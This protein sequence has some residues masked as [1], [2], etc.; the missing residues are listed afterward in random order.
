MKPGTLL[1]GIL[2]AISLYLSGCTSWQASLE[3]TCD[4]YSRDKHFTWDVGM[5]PGDSA[6]VTLCSNP[7]TGFQWSESAQISDETVLK[8]TGHR[9]IPPGEDAPG[10]AGKE[11]WTFKALK[12]G[13]A[14]VFMGYSRPWEGGEKE[15]WSFTATVFVE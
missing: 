5:R 15:E 11:E 13:T 4:H 6:V 3:I 2:A 12:E 8:Q 1:V 7:T 14:T 9:F 10:S